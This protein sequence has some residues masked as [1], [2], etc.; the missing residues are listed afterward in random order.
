[1]LES[2]QATPERGHGTN[3]SSTV[4]Y[5]HLP[6]T[7]TQLPMPGL[8]ESNTN[9]VLRLGRQRRDDFQWHLRN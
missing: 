6:K 8:I 1:M 4:V 9:R 3:P 7:T 2:P 5:T